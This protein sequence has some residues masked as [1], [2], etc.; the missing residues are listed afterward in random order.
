MR[1]IIVL[2]QNN[3]VTQDTAVGHSV[4]RYGEADRRDVFFGVDAIA[5]VHI[6]NENKTETH[7]QVEQH[8]K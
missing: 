5:D 7:Q 3:T 6:N 4:V 8:Q 2:F 1:S